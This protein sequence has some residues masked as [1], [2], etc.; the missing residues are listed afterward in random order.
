MANA[1]A[2][3]ASTALPPCNNISSPAWE[4]SG[5]ADATM[6]LRPTTAAPKAAVDIEATRSAITNAIAGRRKRCRPPEKAWDPRFI[7]VPP[8]ELSEL[9]SFISLDQNRA[10]DFLIFPLQEG[11]WDNL[12]CDE[13]PAGN[14]PRNG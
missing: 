2:T 6:P 3:A 1:V 9:N 8:F 13:W 10:L 5:S 4:A 14:S 12:T 7:R 11:T